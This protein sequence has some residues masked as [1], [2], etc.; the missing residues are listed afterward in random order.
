MIFDAL[1]LHRFS[2]DVAI[3]FLVSDR[4]KDG[5]KDRDEGSILR[6]LNDGPEEYPGKRHI[7]ELLDRFE[8]SGLNGDHQCLVTEALGPW[9]R[10]GLKHERLLPGQSWAVA[11]QLVE[12]T[13]YMHSMNIVHGSRFLPAP[14]CTRGYLEV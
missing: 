12:A 1:L 6:R 7:V 2:R 8:V 11:R 14:S 5:D 13:R 9:L 4:D 3:K 10:R